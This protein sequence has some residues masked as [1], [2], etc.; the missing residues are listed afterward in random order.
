MNFFESLVTAKAD[1]IRLR[2]IPSKI[3]F[4]REESNFFF[5]LLLLEP[6]LDNDYHT[7]FTEHVF[8]VSYIH[9]IHQSNLLTR[10]NKPNQS[11]DL[12]LPIKIRT[13]IYKKIQFT[14]PWKEGGLKETAISLES[15]SIRDQNVSRR[16][17]RSGKKGRDRHGIRAE[18]ARNQGEHAAA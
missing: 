18:Y 1:D 2:S 8:Y 3:I 9:D 11:K 5:F 10:S 15:V 4:S 6:S 13:I 12:F 7:F 17:D 16:R 14:K